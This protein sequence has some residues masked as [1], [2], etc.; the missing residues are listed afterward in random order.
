[1][2]IIYNPFIGTYVSNQYVIIFLCAHVHMVVHQTTSNR[3][4]ERKN[5]L[6]YY[7]SSGEHPRLKIRYPTEIVPNIFDSLRKKCALT[8]LKAKSIF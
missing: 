3:N 7:K 8:E 4:T 5:I 2:R 1:M 6:Y